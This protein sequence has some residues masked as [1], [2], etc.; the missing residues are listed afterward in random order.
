[1]D[2]GKA[3]AARPGADVTKSERILRVLLR[4]VGSVSLVAIVAV[5]MPYSWMDAIHR[6]LGMGE[7]PPDPIVGY[8]ARS[9]SAFYAMMGGLLWL[10]SFDLRRYRAVIGYQSTVLVVFGAVLI[11]VDAVED[12]PAFWTWQEGPFAMA[13]GVAI[14]L[15]RRGVPAVTCDESLSPDGP[16]A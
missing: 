9:T 4:V 7:L 6:R 8:L 16:S 14:L 2:F 12:M 13:M 1:M 5:F 15:L 11:G 10:V 3:R